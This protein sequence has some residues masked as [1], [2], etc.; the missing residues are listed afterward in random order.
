MQITPPKPT[1]MAVYS[2]AGQPECEDP[3]F[4]FTSP[5]N[6]GGNEYRWYDGSDGLADYP[7]GWYCDDCILEGI[8]A[9]ISLGLKDFG[10]SKD[11]G[12]FE[13]RLGPKLHEYLTTQ[14]NA[15]HN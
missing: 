9:E 4:Q 12:D 11:F 5:S 10:S 7:A 8:W 1:V 2:C 6:W 14:W 13:G 15:T 3:G